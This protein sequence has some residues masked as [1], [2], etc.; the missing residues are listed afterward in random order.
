MIDNGKKIN[1][2]SQFAGAIFL[3]LFFGIIY[4]F[5]IIQIVDASVYQEATSKVYNREKVLT[6]NRGTIFDRNGETLA[7]EASSYT[8]VAILS[9]KAPVRVKDPLDAAKKLAPIVNMSVEDLHQ[10]MSQEDRYQVELRP[11]GW[12]LNR[13]SMQKI[14]E[15]EIPG[16][17]FIEEPKRYYPNNDF[18]SHV[19]GFLNHDGKPVLGLEASLN[20]YLKGEDGFVEYTKD[21]KGNPLP[22]G[23]K[24]KEPPE[25]GKNVY[26]TLDERIQLYIE[27]ALTEAEEMYHP[28]KI[29][30][31]AAKPQTGEILGMSSRPSFDPNQYQSIENYVNHAVSSTFEPGSTFKIITLAAAIEEGIYNGNEKYLSGS[32]K[33]PGGTIRDHVRGGWGRISFLEGVQK[34]SNVAFTILGWER[35][36]KD[37]F[38]HYIHRFGFG[39]LTGIDLPNEA[40][41]RVK[42][43]KNLPEI[44]RATMTFGQGVSVTAIQQVAAVNAIANGGKLLKPYIIDRIED[45][46]TG[47]V[48]LKNEPQVVYDQVVSKETS[49]QVA[50]ILETVVTDGTGQNFYIEGYQVAGK[51]GTAQ[52]VG[53]NGKYVHGKYIHSFIGFAPKDN[54]QI[55]LYVVV[56]SP[57][58]SDYRLG[59][60]VVAQ[61]FKSVMQNTLQYLSVQPK[62]ETVEIKEIKD[63]SF[64]LEDYRRKSIMNARDAAVVKGLQVFVFGEEA[65]VTDQYP[66]P[67]SKVYKNDRVYLI[68][69][70]AKSIV[71][72]DFTGWSMRDVRDWAT[73]AKI[74][75]NTIGS[76]YVFKQNLDPGETIPVGGTLK[77]ELKPKYNNKPKA[78]VKTE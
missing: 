15:L 47:E 50:D 5:Y 10:L 48:V 42:S 23:M 13:E 18:A 43:P 32:K 36:P 25:H 1:R 71:I 24:G 44:D 30:V 20:E 66:K 73:I 2:R 72:P 56:D 34:S 45:P 49:K 21:G 78:E 63:E 59:G 76:G 37:V 39:G 40:K 55:V 28:E 14:K 22:Q 11:G 54:P 31:I 38:Y 7:K 29:T 67:N 61:I 19:I 62:V 16:I 68:A 41:G 60:S 69:G 3:L 4:R 6:A 52:K 64:A 33:V 58:V 53:E 74:K 77:I 17:M 57:K 70:E 27:Q 75:V 35:M 26:L 8:A 51:T 65:N 46:S 9:K 12:K